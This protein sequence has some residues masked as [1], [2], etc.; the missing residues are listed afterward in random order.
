MITVFDSSNYAQQVFF[1]K[2]FAYLKAKGEIL[3]P[4]ELSANKFLSLDSYFAH[5]QDLIKIKPSFALIPSDEMPF[6]IDANSRQIKV[7]SEFSRC[8]GVVGDNMCEIATFTI[9]RYFDYVDLANANICVQWETPTHK[10]ISHIGLID[11]DTVSGKIRFGWPLT[12]ELT[13]K[14]GNITFAVRFFIEKAVERGDGKV[15][16]QFVY[17]FN[18][19]PATIPIKSGLNLKGDDLVVEESVG[20]L[21]GQFITNSNNPS[22]PMPQPVT[23]VENLVE[24]AKIAEA[25]NISAGLIADSL[26]LKAQAATP[27]GGHIE[28]NWYLKEGIYDRADLTTIPEKLETDDNFEI[29]DVYVSVGTKLNELKKNKQYYIA[30]GSGESASYYPVRVNTEGKFETQEGE[31]LVDTELFEKYTT[32]TIKPGTGYEKVT[33]LY[34]VGATNY[35]GQ[36]EIE[37]KDEDGNVLY[38]VPGINSTSEVKS[39]QCYVPTPAPVTITTGDLPSNKFTADGKTTLTLTPEVDAGDPQRTY[40]WYKITDELAQ[41]EDKK[42]VLGEANATALPAKSG[43]DK[44]TLEVSAE[45]AG[46]YYAHVDSLL[47]RAHTIADSNI[48]R[49]VN[50]VSQPVITT[51]SYKYWDNTNGIPSFNDSETGW[52]KI[53]NKDGGEVAD[54]IIGGSETGVSFGDRVRLRVN[55]EDLSSKLLS[56]NVTYQWYVIRPDKGDGDRL[57]LDDVGSNSI[58]LSDTFNT[59]ELDV[60]CTDDGKA[61]VYYCE[62]TNTLAGE[63]NALTGADYKE[64]NIAMFT[65]K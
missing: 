33:G 54:A 24:Q 52:N 15:E 34:Y 58:L 5:I 20:D 46:W 35:V 38:T 3:N 32:L 12:A 6:E 22:Y 1:D 19:L 36:T 29:K 17:L 16:Q 13:E 25:D 41:D 4:A 56:D 62:I 39:T 57:T 53:Y 31:V 9:D 18:T 45:E 26:T 8:A 23:F 64:K 50:P 61:Y 10:G 48:C 42:W 43:I 2:A 65:I 37:V 44:N 30:S 59:P 21:F 60:R 51:L 27:D 11:L 55:I 63:D 49:V 14:A 47:N 28:Y 7:P 40:T